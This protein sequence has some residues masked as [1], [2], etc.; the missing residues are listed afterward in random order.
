VAPAPHILGQRRAVAAL[1][2]ALASGHLHHAWILHGPQGVG[3][4][5]AAMALARIVLDPQSTASARASLEPPQG[6]PVARMIDAGTHPDLHV[7]RKELAAVSESRELRDRKQMNI[8]LD[9]L[10]ERMIGGV[11]GEGRHHES[12][13]FRT[14]AMGHGKAFIV[15]EA[16]LLDAD[17]QN[18]MLK[19]LEEPPAGTV[20]VLV[21]QQ[22]DRLLPTIRSRCQ[23]VAFGPLDPASMREWWEREGPKAGDDRAFI[24][25]FAEGSPGMAARASEHGLSAWQR[26]LWPLLDQLESGGFPPNLG[27]RMAEIADEFAKGIVD[28]DEN[29]SKDA[30]NRQA[31][32]LLARLLGLR[33]RQ[34]LARAGDDPAELSR[35]LGAAEVL[36]EFERHVRSNVNLKHAFANLAAQ[37]AER[38]APRAAGTARAR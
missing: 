29:A 4:F 5:R 24:E 3:K 37:W 27:D 7:I 14:A 6:T 25:A 9:L 13:V 21:T 34:S 11:S 17:A 31:V 8:P 2:R 12:A 10:R 19:T 28:A 36:G 16:E 30:A 22:E 15:D 38:T 18:A 26:E 20:I 32:R 1:G 23:R 35:W 33:V